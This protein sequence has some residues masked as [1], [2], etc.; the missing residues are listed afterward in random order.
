LNTPRN[1]ADIF[2]SANVSRRVAIGYGGFVNIPRNTADA[3]I[4]FNSAFA[5]IDLYAKI[6]NLCAVVDKSEKTD[7]IGFRPIDP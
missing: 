2:A 4:S 6:S 5:I 1:T 3:A 7:I